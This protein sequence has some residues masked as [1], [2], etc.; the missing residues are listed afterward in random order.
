MIASVDFSFLSDPLYLKWLVQGTLMTIAIS[1]AG[2]VAA[3]AVG[4]AGA[5]VIQLRI[6]LLQTLARILVDLFR[7]TPPLVQLFFL[8]FMLSDV[9][10]SLTDAAGRSVPLFG[11]F[12]CVVLSLGFYNGAMAVEIIR[13]GIS[14]VPAQTIEGAR[15]LGYSSAQIF[16]RV[17]LPMALRLTVPAMTNNVISL[18]KTSAQASLIA[19]ADV[20]YYAT[21]IMLENFRNLEV[22]IV[23]WLIYLAIA[24]VFAMLAHG[25]ERLL[26]IPGYGAG[27]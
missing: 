14:A 11:G 20:M 19:V 16:R 21:Q 2:M 1:A 27:A 22:M 26:H 23:I 18:I 15:S 9:G 13:S 6:P 8:Y 3:F 12:S 7:N 17:E 25:A 24:S 10:L 5:A 4:V